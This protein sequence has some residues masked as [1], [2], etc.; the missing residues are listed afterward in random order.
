MTDDL[1]RP[2]ATTDDSD[3]TL[4][5]DDALVARFNQFEGIS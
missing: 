5:I 1:S 2:V 3:F 4:T